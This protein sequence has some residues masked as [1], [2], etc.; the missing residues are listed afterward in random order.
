[1][2]ATENSASF[3]LVEAQEIGVI[4]LANLVTGQD[5]DI[6]GIIPVNEGNILIDRIGRAFVPVRAGGL[7]IGRQHMDT[8]MQ[9]VQVPGLAVADILVQDKRADTGSEYRRY[10]Y[11]N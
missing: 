5:D 1:M 8:A 9:A 3:L 2:T 10:Q 6:L 7:L 4:L 11:P